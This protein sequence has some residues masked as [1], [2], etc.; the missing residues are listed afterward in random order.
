LEEYETIYRFSLDGMMLTVPD[1]RI[2]A[3]NP[4]AC[5]MLLFDEEEII[6]L[7]RQGLADPNDDRWEAAVATRARHG[8]TRAELSFRRGDGTTCIV[9]LTSNV[10]TNFDGE[11]RTC[12]VFRDVTDRVGLLEHQARLVEELRGLSLVDELT[13]IRN[14]RGLTSGA[15]VLLAVADRTRKK[16]QVLFIDVDNLKEIN[17]IHGHRRGDEAL[18]SVARAL[19]RSVRAS[20]L[21]ARIGGDEFVGLILDADDVSGEIL[22]QRI[23]S[24]LSHDAVP[25]MKPVSVSIGRASREPGSR[26]SM[27]DLMAEAD[28][29][30]Y[31]S[32]L[33]RRRRTDRPK[34]SAST[35]R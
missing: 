13:G 28:Q 25:G 6:R 35:P 31:A 4:A 26:R 5:R 11:Q 19:Q 14:R 23:V 24:E 3:A 29:L 17:D 21:V 20:D 12:I 27:D 8:R 22:I 10:F 32:R 16:V 9:D 30:M 34:A 33:A 2:L 15:E 7:G 1:G 18:Q